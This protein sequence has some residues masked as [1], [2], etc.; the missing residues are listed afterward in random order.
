MSKKFI[1]ILIGVMTITLLALITVQMFWIRNAVEIKEQQFV[2]LA[3]KAMANVAVRIEE[4]E[5]IL[6]IKNEVISF[7]SDTS[8]MPDQSEIL[9]SKNPILDSAYSPLPNDTTADVFLFSNDSVVYKLEKRTMLDSSTVNEKK[10][11]SREEIKSNIVSKVANKT[12]FVENI[13]NQLIRKEVNIEDRIDKK[14]L[15]IIIS[16]ELNFNGISQSFEYVVRRKNKEFIFHSDKYNPD[17]TQNNYETVLFPNDILSEPNYLSVYFPMKVNFLEPVF[18]MVVSSI[19]LT[20]IILIIFSFTVYTIFRQKKLSEIKTDFVNNMTHELKTPIS[21]ISL[22]AQMLKDT[23]ISIDEKNLAQISKLIDDE[24]KRLGYQV[25]KVLQMAVFEKGINLKIKE[26]NMNQLVT[27][28]SNNFSIN[29]KNRN[30]KISRHQ[31]A[32]RPLILGDK[33]HITNVVVNL[34][35]NAVKYS[36]D[37]PEI[38]IS[39]EN[40]KDQ[41][42][43]SVQDNG[44]GIDKDNFKRIFDKF[45]RVPTGNIHNVKGF[46]LGLSYVQRIVEDH[47][48]KIRV[49]S[50]IGSGTKFALSFPCFIAEQETK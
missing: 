16:K 17:N 30:G 33:V 37:Q 48:G 7:R 35:D 24:S 31:N 4:H 28:V 19:L 5:T 46:G 3:N 27:S 39:T 1:Q 22:A 47:K 2:Q 29:I 15:Q 43:I 38:I 21:T 40:K 6:R 42:I 20:L 25:E 36:T 18:G 10:Q 13:V 9:N 14:L 34:L 8:I 45:Y 11:V 12:I 32:V 50:E 23:S 26:I 49:T 44:I 41:V